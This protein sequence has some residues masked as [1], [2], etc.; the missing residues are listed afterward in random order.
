MHSDT[1]VDSPI[2]VCSVS[3]LTSVNILICLNIGV[4]KTH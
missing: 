2:N 3:P 1:D 4:P